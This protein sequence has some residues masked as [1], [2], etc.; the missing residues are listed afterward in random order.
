MQNLITQ[1]HHEAGRDAGP[2]ALGTDVKAA[3]NVLV[4][5]LLFAE[6]APLKGPLTGSPEF[7]AAFLAQGPQDKQGRSLRQFDLEK[8]LFKFPCSYMIYSDSFNALPRAVKLH[9]YRRLWDVLHGE[10]PDPGWGNV[11]PE[12]RRAILE[13]LTETK[14]DLPVSWTL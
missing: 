8:R 10:N 1:L 14:N 5:Y 4:R 13:I 2:D 3:A 12:T 9:I 6:E 7:T 11:A